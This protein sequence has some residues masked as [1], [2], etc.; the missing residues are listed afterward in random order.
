MNGNE[1]GRRPRGAAH[2]TGERR[3][4]TVVSRLVGRG[5]VDPD[6]V[7][8]AREVVR[9]ALDDRT[10]APAPLRRRLAEVAG[11]IGGSLVV[12]AAVVFL[13]EEWAGLSTGARTATLGAIAVVLFGAAV[14]VT[15]AGRRTVSEAEAE[16]VP[17]QA[18]ER[19][20]RRRLAGALG[21]GGAFAAAFAVAVL[22]EDRA[23]GLSSATWFAGG[24]ALGVTAAGAYLLAPTALGQAGIA[25]GAAL[26]LDSGLDTFLGSADEAHFGVATLV[27][28]AVWLGLTEHGLWW[29]RSAG[30]TIGCVL[31]LLGAQ[32][33]VFGADHA[34]LGYALTA[35]VALVTVV[36]Y[37]RTRA[38]PYLVT[39]VAA[40]TIVVPEALLD[41]TQGSL[42]PVGALLATGITLLV[43]SL[44]GLR[45]RREI[46]HERGADPGAAV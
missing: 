38:V 23:P 30:L 46:G 37:T 18:P 8:E 32:L 16:P 36:V 44:L 24:L 35:A 43:A 10:A 33:P 31:L 3:A 39:A 14:T 27:L 42:G 13:A 1:P 21:T 29:E 34:S 7:E 25:T 40:L 12:A 4:D 19:G 6:R 20:V 9:A 15:L 11:Y 26:A 28:G 5:L 45:L 22:V 41:W 2:A 17:D